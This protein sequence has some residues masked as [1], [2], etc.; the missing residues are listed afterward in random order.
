MLCDIYAFDKDSIFLSNDSQYF[1]DFA[2]VLAGDDFYLIIFFYM[3]LVYHRDQYL[4]Q[5]VLTP[6][7][8]RQHRSGLD[9]L[10]VITR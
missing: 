3:T 1:A 9:Q 6:F 7:M 5:A 8:R 10:S 4:R 2:T